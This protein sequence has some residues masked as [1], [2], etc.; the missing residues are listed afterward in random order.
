MNQPRSLPASPR[1]LG[2][3]WRGLSLLL[4]IACAH[5][6]VGA[7]DERAAKFYEDALV[8]YDK[9]DVAGA[10]IQL[11]NALQIDKTM[12]PVQVLLGKAL[13]QTGDV[14]AAEVAL[15]AAIGLGVNRAEVVVPLAQALI[16]QGKQK[17]LLELTLLNP[18]N[19]PSGLQVQLYL[20]R[21]VALTDLGD[22]RGAMR[23]IEEARVLDPQTADTWL[24]EVP[25]RIRGR[26]FKEATD[27]VARALT[28]TPNSAEAWYQKGA[29]LHVL[30][31]SRSALA[32]YDQ[33]LKID[34][35]HTEARVARAGLL[36][37][38]KQT[39]EA[40]QDLGLLA[41]RSPGEPRAAYLRALLAERN[42]DTPAV[43][44][45]LKQVTNLIDPV[46]VEY[47]RYRP[48]LLMLNGLSHYG[49]NELEKA[50]QYLEAFQKV[51]ANSAASKLLA[52]IYIGQNNLV[53]AV[54][55]L[56]TYLRAQPADS[57]ALTML[58]SAQMSQG[59]HAKAAALMTEA[60]H[61]KDAPEFHTTLGLSLIGAGQAGSGIRELE[62]AIKR[63][64]KQTSAAVALISLYLRSGQANKAVVMAQG[65]VKQ[66]PANP[67][68]LNLLGLAQ[69]Q[70]GN[71]TEA[72]AALEQALQLDASMVSA[73]LNL[74]RL[75]RRAKS[76]DAASASLAAILAADDKNTEAMIEM[77]WL[78][79]RRGQLADAQRWLEKAND[80]S[81]PREVRW[82]LALTDFHLRNNQ[83]AAALP[84]AKTM[85]T[86]APED[87][88]VLFALARAFLANGDNAGARSSMTTATRVAD[89]NPS[90]QVQ[91]ATLQLAA[92]NVNGAA[93]SLEKALATRADFLPALALMTEVELR[94]NEPVKAAKRALAITTKH[95]KRAIGHSLQGDIAVARGQPRL[96]LEAYRRAHQLEP[97]T[98]TL[99]RLFRALSSQG[100]GQPALQ[101]AEQWIRTHPKDAL[102]PMVLADAYAR[103]GNFPAARSAY[104]ALLRTTPDDSVVLNNLANVLLRLKDPGAIKLAE[105]AVAKS[106]GDANAIDTLGLVLFLT[107]QTERALPLLRDARLRD[108]ANPEIRYHLAAVLAQTGRKTEARDELDAALKGARPFDAAPDAAALLK[109]LQ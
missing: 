108:P 90:L 42:K 56:E 31:Q 51:Q 12:L 16:A 4:A 34:D 5:P 75:E 47:I 81:G 69:G 7:A 85:A 19:L 74:A 53:R 61:S 15:M 39:A 41:R 13:L 68:F 107:G 93:Y 28:I 37:D 9:K 25:V 77:A 57:Q 3:R 58:A 46:P 21:S 82:G 80:L 36:I 29:V 60:L 63:D 83:A 35:G 32:A 94:Q 79:E 109:T 100:E 106:P 6:A 22:L 14:A 18:V 2:A 89:Y 30:G 84:V 91:I 44:D 76:F 1:R 62:A 55:V 52:Q 86:K 65:L 43:R 49:L 27:A 24:A 103:A 20:L 87:L 104:E 59:R 54:E 95:P 38:L 40:T 97:S 8:R 26:Q 48:Q 17:Q 10:I 72:R 66:Q 45:A 67:S 101:L 70:A 11:K 64:P 88:L 33:S 98:E 96:A 73:K 23:A 71:L 105:Q 78:A 99:L 50:Q 92:H 102:T